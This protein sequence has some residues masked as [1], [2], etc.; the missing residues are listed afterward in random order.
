MGTC[1]NSPV[2]QLVENTTEKPESMGSNHAV[3]N[4]LVDLV[5]ELVKSN[6]VAAV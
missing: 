5:R 4:R 1:N 6:R 2:A 3:D